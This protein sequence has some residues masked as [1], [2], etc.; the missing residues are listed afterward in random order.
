MR[1]RRFLL[2]GLIVV[3]ACGAVALLWP[4]TTVVKVFEQ[5]PA[6]AYAD[7]SP[8]VAVL[9][10]IHAPIAAVRL[11]GDGFSVQNHYEVVLGR[12][13][14][15]DYG[16]RVRLDATGMDPAELTVEWAPDGA[17]LD[18]RSGHRV[19]VPASSFIGGR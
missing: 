2:V 1:I 9:R 5:P 15:G 6:V 10:H 4:R 12:D 17:W 19:F 13:P 18:Y 16:H 3:A 11:S 14:G 7:G 8:H